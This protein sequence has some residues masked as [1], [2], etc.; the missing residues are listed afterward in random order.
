MRTYTQ[1]T[2]EQRYQHSALLKMGQ[3]QTEIVKVIGAHKLTISRELR[4]NRGQRGYR[5]KQAHQISL[6]IRKKAKPR[7]QEATWALIDSKLQEAWSLEQNSDWLNRN[8]DIQVSHERILEYIL[9]DKRAGGD[10]HKHLHCKKKR[11][12]RY[13][14]D[15]RRWKLPNRVSIDEHPGIVDQRECIGIW[16]LDTMI[17][18]G[19]RQA[20]ETLTERK[21]RFALLRIVERRRADLVF[22]GVIDLLQPL[23][24]R[25]HTITGDNGNGFAELERIPNKLDIDFFFAHP[26]AA[27]ERGTNENVNDLVRQYIPKNRDFALVIDG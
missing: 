12:K 10:L 27:W 22:D 20:I 23:A 8:T 17:G 1:L 18:K 21:S 3:N 15:D 2:H 13:G 14:G 16:E 19:R 24:D 4:R 6:I 25:S 26:H 9:A 5:P 11:R 7:I